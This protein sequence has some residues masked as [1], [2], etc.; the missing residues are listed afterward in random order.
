MGRCLLFILI[1]FF[2][3]SFFLSSFSCF[4]LCVY[5]CHLHWKIQTAQSKIAAIKQAFGFEIYDSMKK[6]DK[7]ATDSIFKRYD[8][9]IKEIESEMVSKK[10]KRTA[11]NVQKVSLMIYCLM[12]I[13]IAVLHRCLT[14]SFLPL[15]FIVLLMLKYCSWEMLRNV[16]FILVVFCSKTS[17]ATDK[18]ATER[19]QRK[20][21]LN[22]NKITN[23]SN[24]DFIVSL[25]EQICSFFGFLFFFW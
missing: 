8:A 12:T 1:L 13:S 4:F 18:C 3:L 22:N 9:K 11:N 7:Q 14:L 25:I 20:K 24:I 21:Y 23:E 6:C 2:F 10:M 16:L 17:A 5:H 19:K 15:D